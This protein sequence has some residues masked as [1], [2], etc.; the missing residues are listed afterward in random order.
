M[1]HEYDGWEPGGTC[2]LCGSHGPHPDYR[3]LAIL[4]DGIIGSLLIFCAF[5]GC[6]VWFS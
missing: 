5:V 4:R 2:R 6:V 1:T 3:R